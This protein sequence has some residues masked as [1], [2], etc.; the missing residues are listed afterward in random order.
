M[1]L[2]LILI[3]FLFN[4]CSFAQE[5]EQPA[6]AG[7]IKD[8]AV[9]FKEKALFGVYPIAIYDINLPGRSF[10]IDFYAWW[11]ADHPEYHPDRNV[12][13][14]NAL[15]YSTKNNIQTKYKDQYSS[16]CRYSATIKKDWDIRNFPFDR[17][18]LQ[19]HLE[20]SFWNET[21]VS[22]IPDLKSSNLHYEMT[23]EGWKIENF[24]IKTDSILYDTNFGAADEEPS[25]FARFTLE[26]DIKRNG[27]SLFF[28]FFIGSFCAFLFNLSRL[29]A[30]TGDIALRSTLC[31]GSILLVT[32]E[33]YLVDGHL[34]TTDYFTLADAI[35]IGTFSLI[36]FST[37]I[38]LYSAFM[39]R[40]GKVAAAEKMNK[41]LSIVSVVAYLIFI[42][43]FTAKA[44]LS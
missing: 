30:K 13:I 5:K 4:S 41:S 44:A 43:F 37:F 35:Q 19:V 1:R 9:G 24:K 12:E 11:L 17:Q 22:W 42:G 7:V 14:T 33:K 36:I 2:F 28:T 23:L 38:D 34:P 40:N 16:V 6:V 27:V 20:D 21:F 31:F 39:I 25:R 10:K 8:R 15:E 26:F 3:L 18:T 29:L 32:G